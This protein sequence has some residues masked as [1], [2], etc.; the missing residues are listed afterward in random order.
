LAQAAAARLPNPRA[1]TAATMPSLVP[2]LLVLAGL[3]GLASAGRIVEFGQ[4]GDCASSVPNSV[5]RSGFGWSFKCKCPASHVLKGENPLCRDGAAVEGKRR[6]DPTKLAG[7]GCRCEDHS[8]SPLVTDWKTC[9]GGMLC[10]V[11]QASGLYFDCFFAGL[12][13]EAGDIMFLHGF[14]EWRDM[15]IPVINRFTP[16]G[17]RSIACNQRGYSRRAGPVERSEYHY[18]KLRDDIFAVADAVGFGRF[19]V[20][21]HDH[22]AV[23][24]WY[25]AGSER[26]RERFLSF[27]ALSVPHPDAFSAGLFGPDAD[28]EQQMASQYFTSLSLKD[29]ASLHG[30]F[31][32]YLLGLPAGFA[33]TGSFQ[34][35][36]WWYNGAM[37]AGVMSAPPFM[38]AKELKDNSNAWTLRK[39]FGDEV[40]PSYIKDG[41]A[42]THPTGEIAM[43]ALY[44]CG[45][46]DTA[47]LCKRPYAL[48]TKD[49]CTGG[50]QY[51]EVDCGHDILSCGASAATEEVIDAVVKH[52]TSS[53]AA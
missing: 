50:Y 11:V 18:D 4:G 31:L 13:G 42:A 45:K 44:V 39:V 36:L 53:H 12:D 29:S 47:I 9:T 7:A 27:A 22:G 16:L 24:G 41:W 23:L 49:Y 52:V 46:T 48:K 15:Y 2:L 51:V 26:G 14:P 3:T 10:T 6:F 25:A 5:P 28:K 40:P 20:V 1:T 8:P 21:A 35:A 30:G 19:H 37:E 17:Y 33:S 34:K 32:Y 38:T 43:P